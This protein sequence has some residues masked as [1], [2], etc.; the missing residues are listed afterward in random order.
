MPQYRIAQTNTPTTEQGCTKNYAYHSTRRPPKNTT[1]TVKD[2]P[3]KYPYHSKGIPKKYLYHRTVWPPKKTT[4]VQGSQT[5]TLT[6]YRT[7]QRNTSIIVQEC[8]K[9]YLYHSTVLPKKMPQYRIAQKCFYHST[10]QAPENTPTKVQ[11]T[12]KILLAHF[13]II[14]KAK[15]DFLNIKSC[16]CN[17]KRGIHG[18]GV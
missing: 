9:K 4:T 18:K 6:Q 16:F 2:C 15:K 8:P 5:N 1:T 7:T 3:S 14:Q 10:V 12:E 13:R 11:Q 17:I